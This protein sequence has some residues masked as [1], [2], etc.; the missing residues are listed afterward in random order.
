VA[1]AQDDNPDALIESARAL[2]TGAVLSEIFEDRWDMLEHLISTQSSTPGHWSE[3]EWLTLEFTAALDA[4]GRILPEHIANYRYLQRLWADIPSVRFDGRVRVRALGGAP[5]DLIRILFHCLEVGGPLDQATYAAVRAE[6]GL[7]GGATTRVAVRTTGS[8]TRWRIV[9]CPID[10]LGD[11][12]R[13]RAAI[14][15]QLPDGFQGEVIV[16][17]AV[18]G[19]TAGCSTWSRLCG[20]EYDQARAEH[21]NCQHMFRPTVFRKPTG[22]TGEPVFTHLDR[23]TG[24]KI[25]LTYDPTAGCVCQCGN[26]ADTEGTFVTCDVVGNKIEPPAA[27]SWAS[28]VRCTECNLVVD[29]SAVDHTR[30]RVAAVGWART[31]TGH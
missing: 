17:D 29:L 11:E 12:S 23:V 27:D 21:R 10:A 16:I 19:F 31:L 4:E 9:D 30:H 28:L 13:E 1:I 25:Y 26:R 6:L 24:F 14:T 20:E 2:S 22:D 15:Q 8:D 5:E 3:H 7:A 18:P